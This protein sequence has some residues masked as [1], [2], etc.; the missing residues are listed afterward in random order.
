MSVSATM[1]NVLLTLLMTS[2]MWMKL[3]LFD[4][5]TLDDTFLLLVALQNV[6]CKSNMK[7]AAFFYSAIF[8][9]S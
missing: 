6:S 5:M 7:T 8:Y 3:P 2:V 9:S 1:E 4:K